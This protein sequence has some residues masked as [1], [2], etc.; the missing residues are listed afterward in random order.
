[1]PT[2]VSDFIADDLT[3]HTL[4]LTRLS[5][6]T[7]RKILGQ[8]RRLQD[9]LIEK[10]GSIGVDASPSEVTRL[11]RLRKLEEQVNKT[12][13]AAYKRSREILTDDLVDLSELE[14]S[15]ALKAINKPLKVELATTAITPQIARSIVSKQVVQGASTREWWNRQSRNL[16]NRFKDE[17]T[18]GILA[19][20]ATNALVQRVRGTATG[21]RVTYEIDGKKRS[22]RE[23]RGGIMDASTREATALVRTSVQNVANTSRLETYKQNGDVIKQVQVLV[24]LDSRTTAIC[25]ARSGK[26]WDLKTFEPVGHSEGFPGSPPWHFNC[27]STL[28]PITKSFEELTQEFDGNTKLAKKLKEVPKGTQSSMNGQV[29]ADI[30]YQQWLKGRPKSFQKQVLGP[31]KFKLFEQGKLQLTDLISAQTGK[32][33]TVEQ[34]KLKLEPGATEVIPKGPPA[35]GRYASE[36]GTLKEKKDFI[37]TDKNSKLIR[38]EALDTIAGVEFPKH[39]VDNLDDLVIGDQDVIAFLDAADLLDDV[40]MGE[41]LLEAINNDWLSSSTWNLSSVLQQAA[42]QEFGLAGAPTAH[43]EFS[44]GYK[45]AQ[46]IINNEQAMLGARKIAR[47]I[48]DGTQQYFKEK[49]ITHVYAYRGALYQ[50]P[51]TALK[52]LADSKGGLD[53]IPSVRIEV[54]QQPLNSW[55]VDLDISKDFAG[56]YIHSIT[57]EVPKDAVG[58]LYASKIPVKRIFSTSN[59]AMGS[60]EQM[61]LVVLGGDDVLN[62]VLFDNPYQRVFVEGMKETEFIYKLLEAVD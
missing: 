47:A 36:G 25:Q 6:G 12:I 39:L 45:V 15:E 24:T 48:Y 44:Q 61:E 20:E 21:K 60:I 14:T 54:S 35:L 38:Q 55:S 16:Q 56:G 46:S 5:A 32:P 33:L 49:G 41:E 3:A 1:M 18:Q 62:T 27:R 11:R 28:L 37:W 31:S 8:L 58:A 57:G 17:M 13:K 4:D 9:S 22:F 30:G 34:L 10:I 50:R 42:K 51:P 59:T 2:S 23:F 40:K 53:R 26:I 7:S 52:E 43:F 19:G 29:A